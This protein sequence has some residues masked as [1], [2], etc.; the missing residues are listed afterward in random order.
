MPAWGEQ[1]VASRHA[2]RVA[3]H[4]RPD[5]V[6]LDHEAE[7]VL[8]VAMLGRGFSRPEILDRG[9]ERGRDIGVWREPGIREAKRA[10]LA[11]STHRNQLAR[12]LGQRQKFG[13]FPQ[14]RDRLRFGVHRHQ[15][16]QLGPER[17]LMLR[18]SK[19]S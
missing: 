15:V 19:L 11:A 10:A 6:T 12:L 2:H 9:P 16:A 4:D 8:R 18:F 13:P 5:P 1:Q 3:V 14:V 17:G 7:G